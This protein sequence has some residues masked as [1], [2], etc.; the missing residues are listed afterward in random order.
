MSRDHETDKRRKA[1]IR[2]IY[3][4]MSPYYKESFVRPDIHGSW[5][6]DRLA[7]YWKENTAYRW[8]GKNPGWWDR[9]YTTVPNRRKA[10]ALCY[11]I[12]R[13]ADPDGVLWPQDR[14][15]TEYYW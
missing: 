13:G 8:T 10:N 1:R 11:K 14:L 3:D 7:R 2:L 5:Y 9:L 15:P 4:Q 12:A 6:R